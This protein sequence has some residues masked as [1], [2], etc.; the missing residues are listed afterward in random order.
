[1]ATQIMQPSRKNNAND[2]VFNWKGVDR[3]GQ[4]MQGQ[5]RA[6]SAIGAREAL[7]KQG[8]RPTAVSQQ[9]FTVGQSIKPKEIALFTRQLST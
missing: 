2:G 5:L 7:R 1:M 8:I 9:S 4:A 3:K 6:A